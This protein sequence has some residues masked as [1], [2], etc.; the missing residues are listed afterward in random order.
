MYRYT[1]HLDDGDTVI[2]EGSTLSHDPHAETVRILADSNT[3]VFW[4]PSSRIRNILIEP[5]G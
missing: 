3:S 5:V 1:I 4:A 2:V